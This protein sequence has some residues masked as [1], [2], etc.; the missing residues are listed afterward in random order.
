MFYDSLSFY[1]CEYM[2]GFLCV[3][4]SLCRC[5]QKPKEG[6]NFIGAGVTGGDEYPTI[7]I[8]M[9]LLFYRK[10]PISSKTIACEHIQRM[11]QE[12]GKDFNC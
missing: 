3:M 10:A 11:L 12:N 1:V 8:G 6:F 5:F 2:Y 9:G 4:T 7:L